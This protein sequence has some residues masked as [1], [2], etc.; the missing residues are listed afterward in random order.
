M[1]TAPPCIITSC[2]ATKPPPAK[3]LAALAFAPDA[4]IHFL[5]EAANALAEAGWRSV[6]EETLAPLLADPKA[7]RNIGRFWV[8]AWAPDKQWRKLRQLEQRS[9]SEP[10]RRLAWAEALEQL[11]RA[12]AIWRL[13]WHRWRRG[14]WLRAGSETWGAFGYALITAG[15]PAVVI[16]W[17]HDWRER[18]DL[19]P[20]MLHNL[21]CAYY[22][23]K[24]PSLALAVVDQ[25]LTLKPDHTR[26][27]FLIWRGL[28]N[29][30]RGETAAAATALA[31]TSNAVTADYMKFE[32]TLL[33]I[34]V[35]FEQARAA[36]SR[37]AL[38][39]AKNRLAEHWIASPT[40]HGDT[41]LVHFR[42]RALRHL[43]A[44]SGSRFTQIQS[45]FPPP[46][47]KY[48]ASPDV[49]FALRYWWVIWIAFLVIRS[50]IN[51]L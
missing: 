48:R 47:R 38:R 51:G 46:G 25:A 44:R 49:G 3:A 9:A 14:D 32:R 22:H 6:T 43:A 16:K 7:H 18:T 29:L 28:E 21:A 12:R 40:A 26:P 8:A 5:D 17:C 2:A 15:Q 37:T 1:P 24:K 27:G 31:Q 20:W 50:L 33:E 10:V 13:R 36:S 42:A 23:R 11:G 19:E 39:D 41:S 4:Q 45:F 35:A 30:F 34:L